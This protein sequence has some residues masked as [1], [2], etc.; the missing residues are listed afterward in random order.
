MLRYLITQHRYHFLTLFGFEG[1]YSLQSKEPHLASQIPRDA[2]IMERRRRVWRIG[3][4]LGALLVTVAL[5][6]SVVVFM[7]RPESVEPR[8][9][10]NDLFHKSLFYDQ[11]LQ[12]MTWSLASD[13]ICVLIRKIERIRHN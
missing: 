12:I 6:V 5:A 10:E 9:G 11:S 8:I 13:R 3:A 4:I 2:A 1:S 7:H